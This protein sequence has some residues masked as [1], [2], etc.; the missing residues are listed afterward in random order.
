MSQDRPPPLRIAMWSGP[1]NLST[2][3]M[4]SFGNRPDCTVSDEPFYACYLK[5]TGIDHPMRD[6]ILRHHENDGSKVDSALAGAAPGGKKIW[7]QK[8]MTHHMLPQIGRGFMR[9]C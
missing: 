4:R 9:F 7:Y 1:R 8:H 5:L 6:E 3:L 2:A